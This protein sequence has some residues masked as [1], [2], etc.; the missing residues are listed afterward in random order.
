[1]DVRTALK[2]QY[3][4]ALV[5]L[6]QTIAQCPEELWAGGD[7]SVA[8]WRVVYH[9][10][11][12]T[13]LY[14]QPDVASFRPWEHHRDQHECLG[15]LPYPPYGQPAIGEPYTRSQLLE[16][17]RLCDGLVDN[18][19]DQLDIDAA[20]CGFP[21][22]KLSKLEHQINNIRHIQHHAA[23]LAGRLRHARGTDVAWVGFG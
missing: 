2:G 17:W 11:F 15:E 4:A 6:K 16:Y 14:L 3:H 8:F 13:H 5:M 21:W 22:Y 1:M 9:T 12:F 7:A 18:A 20:E 23:L 19:V 10:L